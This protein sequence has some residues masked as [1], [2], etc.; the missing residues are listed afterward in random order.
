MDTG[1]MAK[2][3]A[4]VEG[5][6]GLKSCVVVCCS[7]VES[8]LRCVAVG[9]SDGGRL[10]WRATPYAY[11][12]VYM[13]IHMY[14]QMCLSVIF[15]YVCLAEAA[16]VSPQP[17]RRPHK[18]RSNKRQTR[19]HSA[20]TSGAKTRYPILNRLILYRATTQRLRILH[21]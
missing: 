3:E 2:S 15:L 19:P 5:R 10:Q 20:S 1:G 16:K 11:A 13:N 17:T 12:Y 21:V 4:S 8:T 7:G 18:Q 9:W 6:G 14:L